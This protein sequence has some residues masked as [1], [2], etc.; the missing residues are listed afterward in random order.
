MNN[1]LTKQFIPQEEI[2]AGSASFTEPTQE[3][4]KGYV[5]VVDETV[6]SF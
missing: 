5:L 1:L 4:M 6:L 3:K 2:T